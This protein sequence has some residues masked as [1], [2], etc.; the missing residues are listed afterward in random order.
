VADHLRRRAFVGD[1][2]L[3]DRLVVPVPNGE[4]E[5]ERWRVLRRRPEA[6]ARLLE[7]LDDHAIAVPWSV[8]RAQQFE[9]RYDE[10]RGTDAG[11]TSAAVRDDVA[12]AV[13]FDASNVAG[14]RHQQ[15]QQRAALPSAPDPD[16]PAFLATRMVLVDEFGSNRDKALVHRL[17]LAPEVEAAVAYGSYRRFRADRGALGP[18]GAQDPVYTFTWPFFAPSDPARSDEDL[19]RQAVELADAEEIKDWREAVQRWRQNCVLRGESDADALRDL[20]DL[21]RAYGDQARRRRIRVGLRYGFAVTAAVAGA[22]AVAVPPVGAA[23]AVFGL[24]SLIPDH[25][26]PK[27]LTAAAMFYEARRKLRR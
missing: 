22:V 16:D 19:L 24:G 5:A 26:I 6:Q 20:E 7:I 9:R 13:S 15:M 12:A 17:P 25:Q 10:I 21:I 8:E 23:A 11:A 14:A 18:V 4:Q 27:R 2:L 1:V 3:Y